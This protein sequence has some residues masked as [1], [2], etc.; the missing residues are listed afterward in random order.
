M[1]KINSRSKGQRGERSCR[2]IFN[3]WWG[4][5]FTRTPSSGGLATILHRGDLNVAGDISTTDPSF[6]WVVE[7][8]HHESV[9]VEHILTAKKSPI[10]DWWKQASAAAMLEHKEPLL[11][12]RKNNSAW[13]Y[14]MQSKQAAQLGGTRFKIVDSEFGAEVTLGLL[15]DLCKTAPELWRTK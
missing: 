12:F 8:K 15:A 9:S 10:Y 3:K 6:P 11:L 1:G 13:L 7:V 2:D 14:M 5:G 4:P